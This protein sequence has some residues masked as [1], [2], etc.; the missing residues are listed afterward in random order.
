MVLWF[1]GGRVLFEPLYLVPVLGSAFLALCAETPAGFLG[2]GVLAALAFSTK[3]YGGQALA[4]LIMFLL[5]GPARWRRTGLVLAGFAGGCV[6]LALFFTALG[7]DMRGLVTQ[8]LGASYP[9]R[10]ESVWLRLF[11]HHCPVA[12]L[13]LLAPFVKGAFARPSVKLAVS[14]GLAA[15]LP[16]YFRQHQYYFLNPTPWLF[17]LFALGAAQLVLVRPWLE[18]W[19]PLAAGLLLTVPLR[20]ALDERELHQSALRSEQL[21]RARLMNLEWAPEQPTLLLANP[22]L[23]SITHY[24][25]GDEV[26]LGYRFLNECDAPALIQGF[27]HAGAVWIDPRGMYARGVDSVLEAA[28]SSVEEQLRTNGFER[29]TVVEE[30]FE[31]WVKSR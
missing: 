8:A 7:A 9:R 13:A 27:R 25:S 14:F 29:R 24:R 15:C 4:G 3:Q 22:G 11:L 30:R 10:Y 1:D 2:A 21:R 20:G 12:V 16:F 17:A 28:G 19:A 18:R 6:L 26:S 5:L 31:L 23:Y